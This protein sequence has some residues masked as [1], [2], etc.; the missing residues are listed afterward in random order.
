MQTEKSERAD[1]KQLNFPEPPTP[2]SQQSADVLSS[3]P[4]S[5]SGLGVP[6]VVMIVG[7]SDED[8][9]AR[10]PSIPPGRR[11]VGGSLLFSHSFYV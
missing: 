5:S 8:L 3:E 2:W 7:A 10:P 9:E 4:R 1:K 11:A 6:S